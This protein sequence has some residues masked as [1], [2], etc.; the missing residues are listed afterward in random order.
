ML[1]SGCAG[2]ATRVGRGRVGR[3]RRGARPRA[4]FLGA[5]RV[6]ARRQGSR[7]CPPD[8]AFAGR[9]GVGDGRGEVVSLVWRGASVVPGFRSNSSPTITMGAGVYVD[10]HTTG[11][12]RSPAIA[13]VALLVAPPVRLH[14]SPRSQPRFRSSQLR[15]GMAPG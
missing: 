11:E 2:R 8:R 7:H 12:F 4:S 15:P 10:P 1:G 14:Q 6:V 5:R 3:G 9:R 13:T